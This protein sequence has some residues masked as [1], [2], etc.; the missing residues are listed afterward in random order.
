MDNIGAQQDF[1]F[2]LHQMFRVRI[3]IL[4]KWDHPEKVYMDEDCRLYVDYVYPVV[5]NHNAFLYTQLPQK[6][7]RLAVSHITAA[8]FLKGFDF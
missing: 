5:E 8:T 3:P 7:A 2:V 4:N 6:E 1:G